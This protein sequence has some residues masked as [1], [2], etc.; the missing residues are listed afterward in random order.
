MEHLRNFLLRQNNIEVYSA[1]LAFLG[2]PQKDL[3]DEIV[4][5]CPSEIQDEMAKK[6]DMVYQ[7]FKNERTVYE[8]EY[9]LG[10]AVIW[11]EVLIA[12][13]RIS[14]A[15][16]KIQVISLHPDTTNYAQSSKEIYKLLCIYSEM[17]IALSNLEQV[18]GVDRF[19][20]RISGSTFDVLDD[21]V[22]NAKRV[23]EA[24]SLNY[25]EA[26]QKIW[27]TTNVNKLIRH[28]L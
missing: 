24:K 22:C 13:K 28:K 21:L 27:N 6:L 20:D 26:F 4:L 3:I 19:L 8:N 23:I 18:L 25:K 11:Q 7:L 17:Q 12:Y 9:R 5:Q 1:V 14:N 2:S 10:Q 15:I 16:A